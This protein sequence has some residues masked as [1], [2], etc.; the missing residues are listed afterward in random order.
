MRQFT[1]ATA[2]LLFWSLIVH[3]IAIADTLKR[4]QDKRECMEHLRAIGK[5][6]ETYKAEHQ[7]EMP[8]WLSDLYPKYLKAPQLLLCPADETGGV[9][10]HFT[11]YKEPKMPCSY[12]YE[13][14]PMPLAS[15]GGFFDIVPEKDYTNKEIKKIQLKYF[16]NLVP[17]VRCRHHG[18]Q[19][20]NLGYGGRVYVSRPEWE[21]TPEAVKA[22]RSFFQSAIEQNPDGWDRALSLENMYKYFSMCDRLPELRVL[23][24]K[25]SNL[26][27]DALKIL[28]EIYQSEG[29][30]NETI[31]I[32]SRMV[33]LVPNDTNIRFQLA[34][35]YATVE[36]YHA[37]QNQCQQIIQLEPDNSKVYGLLAELDAIRDGHRIQKGFSEMHYLVK[38][39]EML[40]SS[41]KE[42]KPAVRKARAILQESFGESTPVTRL[43]SLYQT[44]EKSLARFSGQWNTYTTSDGVIND[45]VYAIAQDSRGVLWIGTRRGVCQYDGENFTPF[46]IN[47]ELHESV[48]R[49]ILIDDKREHIW[50]GTT[51]HGVFRYDGENLVNYTIEDGLA[52][53]SIYNLLQ[54]RNGF[55]WFTCGSG[56]LS[57]YDGK[58][59]ENFTTEDGLVHNQVYAITEDSRGNLWIGTR[60]GVSKYDGNIFTNFTEKEDGLV[61]HTVWAIA[62]DNDE[63]LWFGTN[64]SIS[65]YGGGKLTN[66]TPNDGLVGD[67]ISDILKDCEGN[68]WFSTRGQGA[69][70]YNGTRLIN[71][72]R[73]D[74]LA[75]D[76]IRT[77]FED[78]EGNLWFGHG[79][80]NGLSRLSPGGLKNYGIQD[81]LPGTVVYSIAKDYRGNLWIATDGGIGKYDGTTFTQPIAESKRTLGNVSVILE[82]SARGRASGHN[83]WFAPKN[84]GLIRYDGTDYAYFTTL[85]GLVGNT[86]VSIIENKNGAL[87]MATPGGGI[88]RYDGKAFTSFTMADGIACD[89]VTSFTEDNHGN[90]WIGTDGGGISRYDGTQ[91]TNFMSDDGLVDNR[92]RSIFT[93][94]QGQIWIGTMSG[95]SKYN[96]TS[97]TTPPQFIGEDIQ[98]IIEDEDGYLWFGTANGGVIKTDGAAFTNITTADGLPNNR[99]SALQEDEDGNIWIGTEEGLTKYIPNPILPLIHIESVIAGRI[100]TT[101]TTI[102][103]PA[104]IGHLR[105]NYRGISF[106]TRPEAMQYFY[107]LQR[108]DVERAA[109]SFNDWQGPT[110]ERNV[111]YL[112]LRPG[113]YIFKVKA[114]DIDLNYSEPAS[115]EIKILPPPFYTRA[116][117]II[118]SIFVAFF[119]P[120]ITYALLLARQKRQQPFEPIP[121]PYMAG[122]PIRSEEMFFGREEDFRFVEN[123]LK[124]EKEGIIIVFYGQRRCG[125]TSLLHQIL[126]GRLGDDFMPVLIDMQEMVVYN[127]GE[128]YEKIADEISFGLSRLLDANTDEYDFRTEDTNPAHVFERFI[129][130]IMEKLSDKVLLLMFDEYE[131]IEEKMD[132]N[133]LSSGIPTFF[134]GILERHPRISFIFT[135]SRHVEQQNPQYWSVLFGKS[136]AQRISLLSER[137]TLKLIKEPVADFVKYQRDVPQRIY[138]LTGGQPF[139]TQHICQLLIERLNEVERD[140][141]YASDVEKT[142]LELSDNSPPQMMY[143]WN[144]EL[145]SKEKLALVLLERLL[146]KPENYASA[147]MVEEYI[148]SREEDIYLETSETTRILDGLCQYE[149]LQQEKVSEEAYEYR[150]KIDLFRYWVRRH[151]SI[152]KVMREMDEEVK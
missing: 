109:S 91:F 107:Q 146:D 112:D 66:F 121:N 147:G 59:F 82:D 127:D 29:K 84:R 55:L 42:L 148:A 54:D 100:Y 19:V 7:D 72:T 117:F 62:E 14:N 105:I 124:T 123:K 12:L 39:E 131:L 125:K 41:Q 48:T 43:K 53:D 143:F 79:N 115:L 151:Q 120:T 102:S 1:I 86:V 149:L 24:A 74:G 134:A 73:Q 103:L 78:R 27:V 60:D 98:T 75:G 23:L 138:R 97:F 139:Y 11:T 132:D 114:V 28:A 94:T 26:S 140:K 128:F 150:Y 64:K 69:H 65:R 71:L 51:S 137:D 63:H 30:I 47:K 20:L 61:A 46:T 40:L 87:W 113:T 129:D 8:D 77:V 44:L 2:I 38:L 108:R 18:K 21:W 96:G 70:C 58:T 57:R 101:P 88:S 106:R 80:A 76:D 111:D 126:N 37:A 92:V 6:I 145:N 93:D 5:A 118:S 34:K 116:G 56:G 68:L 83:L 52:G 15:V 22:V 95:A 81:G 136:T 141:V 90:I 45:Y 32:Y 10:A 67:G 35:L 110:N 16:G 89:R 13:F 152:S 133:I 25:Q 3:S 99:V 119:I 36:D 85:D 142:A 130:D 50:F 9:P 4:G 122:G 31:E 104:G 49:A 135:G 17:V 144:E 33:H